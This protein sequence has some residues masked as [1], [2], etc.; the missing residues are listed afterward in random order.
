MFDRNA[1][2]VKWLEKAHTLF[3]SRVSEICKVASSQKV[4]NHIE[5]VNNP[6]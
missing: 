1:E 5:K 3:L 6:S 2:P 4:W